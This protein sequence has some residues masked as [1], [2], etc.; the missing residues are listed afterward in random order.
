MNKAS[1]LLP[2][3]SLSLLLT[4]CAGWVFPA[5]G[6][7]IEASRTVV[8][9]TRE[10][11]GFHA[12][13]MRGVG[14]IL[15]TQGETESLEVSGPGNIVALTGTSV[16]G[17]VLVIELKENVIL[18]HT[19]PADVLTV[20]VTVR[21]LDALTV[22]GIADV[23][24]DGLAGSGLEVEVSGTGRIDL[25]GL[26]LGS[27]RL[28]LSGLSDVEL[29]GRSESAEIDLSGAG[30]VAAGGLALQTARISLSGAGNAR[31]WVAG[32]LTGDIS[33]AGNVEY[34]G[35]PEA[36]LEASGLGRF[37]SLGSK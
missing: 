6:R 5:G 4:G 19:N 32:D 33:G 1:R 26:D 36:H 22:S 27:L 13:E 16:R 8:R 24:M 3:L 29:S 14:R 17:G 21:D 10:A 20:S 25:R 28:D 12:V 2:L 35:N 34:Y 30:N 18:R 9:E 37:K 15:L 11:S 23:R 31:L 7:F